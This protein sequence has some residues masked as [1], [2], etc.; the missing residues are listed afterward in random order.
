MWRACAEQLVFKQGLDPK[1]T[2]T[3]SDWHIVTFVLAVWT[4]VSESP[5]VR[6]RASTSRHA[7]SCTVH[8]VQ[9]TGSWCVTAGLH[10]ILL[11]VWQSYEGRY[12]TFV[13]GECTLMYIRKALASIALYE[14]FTYFYKTF[15]RD[16]SGQRRECYRS[17]AYDDSPSPLITRV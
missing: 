10:N 15:H 9:A 17:S 12:M 11:F 5:N 13:Q 1:G 14:F 16:V 4:T 2:S 7:S 8:C 6:Y 3:L